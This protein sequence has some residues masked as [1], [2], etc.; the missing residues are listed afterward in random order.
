MKKIVVNF[1]ILVILMLP[2]LAYSQGASYS[3]PYEISSPLTY[4]N[5]KNLI[6]EGLGFTNSD[7]LVSG[8]RC[9]SLWNCENVIIR[10]C[11]FQD[12]T[13]NTAVYANESTNITVTNCV[14]ENV[15]KAFL[16]GNC[17][18]WIKFEENNVKNVVGNLYGGSVFSQAVQFNSCVGPGN[19]IS[20]N[21]VENIPGESSPED[22]ISIFHSNGTAESPIIIRGNWIRGGGPSAS[23][24]GILLGDWGGSYQIAE[25]NILVN[26]GQYGMGIAGGHDMI[27]KNNK[28]YARQQSFTNVGLS[29]CNWTQKQTGP[30]SNIVV[31][32]NSI[33][34]TKKDGSINTAWIYENMY[35]AFPDWQ[36]ADIPDLS[37]TEDILPDIILNRNAMETKEQ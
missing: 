36:K 15:S 3:G 30:S 25:D 22:A 5:E 35:E 10:N 11:K 34:W 28:I 24:G 6:I 32:N 16:A 18:G 17:K 9:I 8:G 29:I 12:V 31:E 14:F 2:S 37:I 33:N 7:S 4:T 13:L 19:S 1:I 21:V 20:Y 26:P 27:I 23:G